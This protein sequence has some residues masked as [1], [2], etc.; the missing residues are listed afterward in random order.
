MFRS[1]STIAAVVLLA[2]TLGACAPARRDVAFQTPPAPRGLT[3]DTASA[4]VMTFGR[5]TAR[6]RSEI[7]L[8]TQSTDLRGYMFSSGLRRIQVVQQTT[9]CVPGYG[10]AIAN[11][12]HCTARAQM[13]GR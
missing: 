8:K 12:Y 5:A 9:D 4:K 7:A 3:C 2:A 1:V 6:M 10:G 13:C 11:L